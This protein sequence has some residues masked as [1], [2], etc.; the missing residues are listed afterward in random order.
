VSLPSVALPSD[1]KLKLAWIGEVAVGE[2]VQKLKT[3]DAVKPGRTCRHA[4]D[5]HRLVESKLKNTNLNE[6]DRVGPDIGTAEGHTGQRDSPAQQTI[7]FIQQQFKTGVCRAGPGVRQKNTGDPLA[8]LGL[9]KNH[10]DDRPIV[11]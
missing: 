6:V 8:S 4:H 11:Q 10:L 9:G 5:R 1:L 3:R 2:A 7:L